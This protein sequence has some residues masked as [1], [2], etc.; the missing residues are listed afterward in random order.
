[1]KEL[2]F[3]KWVQR[4]PKQ[5]VNDNDSLL[6]KVAKIRGIKDINRFLNPS[7]EEMFDPYLLKN[8]E[9]AS[10]RILRAIANGEKIIASCDPDAD[11]I[12]A[13]TI[14]LR[15]LR[16]Y[17]DN[18][19][20]IYGERDDGH[21]IYEMTRITDDKK[22]SDKELDEK[23]IERQARMEENIRKISECNLL[24]LIDSSS[25]DTKACKKIVEDFGIDIIVL[26]HHAIERE[27]PYVTLVNPQQEGDEYPNK[28]ISGAGVVFKVVQVLEDTLQQVDPFQYM[29]LVAV[30]MYAD[31]MRVDVLENRFM[32]MH[33]LRNVKNVGLLR[34][35]K[36]GK[37]DLFKINSNAIGFTIAP[38][39]NG[40]ARMGE[41]KLAID[42][43]LT[44]DDNEAKKLRLKMQKLNDK[45]K[46]LQKEIVGQYMKKI[47]PEHKIL[48]VTD[49]QTSKGFNGIVAQQLTEIYRRPVIVGRLHK[50]SI[51]GSFRSYNGFDLKTFLNE[52]NLVKESL[53][54][55]EAGGF[56]IEE[57]KLDELIEYI[58]NNLPDIEEKEPYVLYDIEIDVKDI[59]SYAKSMEYVNLITGNG[60]RKIVVKV[61]GI[62]VER[63][64][65][66][67]STRETVKIKTFDE[68]ELIKFRVNE[69]YASE[70][71]VFDT[72]EVV[73]QLSINEF[74]NF[75]LKQK[76][77]T[78]QIIL[79]DYALVE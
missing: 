43:L 66:I 72:I 1:M 67:G 33:G 31:V 51:A 77:I 57:G 10:N 56:V 19:D 73:G 75:G 48:I 53:G 37:V 21:G 58:N 39:I 59:P 42:I 78:N 40:V 23:E 44:D 63:V 12:T 30:G 64:D 28:S 41:I 62:N 14:M 68:I 60:F 9:S 76:I 55:P 45:R 15:H 6:E 8:I 74:Y 49:E 27:N 69:D 13:L 52:S 24:I 54:H 70:L 16:K 17:T 46:E 18:V 26:D 4:S 71:G 22:E 32:I 35:L 20:Y 47:N 5:A 11:G 7:K 29:D 79:D 61:T 50:G 34:I 3:M 65:C 38:L 25:N 36:G 2:M